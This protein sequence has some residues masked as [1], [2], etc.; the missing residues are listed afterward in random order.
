MKESITKLMNLTKSRSREIVSNGDTLTPILLIEEPEGISVV[1]VVMNQELKD[2][3]QEVLTNILREADATGYVLVL[4]AWS[5]TSMRPLTERIAV[6]ELPLDDRSEI[7][8]ILAVEKGREVLCMDAK[9][10][11]IR[12]RRCLSEFRG[13]SGYPLEGRCIVKEW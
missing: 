1:G 6:S 13:I 9:I 3:A 5:T 4:E 7:V 2:R 11:D 8:M 10:T 12:G